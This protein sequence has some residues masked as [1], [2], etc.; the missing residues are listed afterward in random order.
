MYIIIIPF[1]RIYTNQVLTAFIPT[2]ILWLYG[3]ST[4]YID[5]DRHIDRFMGAGTALLVVATLRSAINS[6]L[7]KTSYMKY[8]D[9]WLVWHVISIFLM[10]SYHIFLGRVQK[11]YQ[12]RHMDEVEGKED[13]EEGKKRVKMT[14]KEKITRIDNNFIITFPLLNSLFYGV[15]FY[16]TLT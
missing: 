16:V 4:L 6:D 2:L 11:Y 1:K 5:P 10:I 15:Y 8:I 13:E 7:P 12:T 9:L 14:D 3:Y